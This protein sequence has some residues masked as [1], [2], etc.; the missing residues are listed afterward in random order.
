MQRRIYRLLP[1]LLLFSASL[2]AAGAS[3]NHTERDANSALPFAPAEVLIYEGEYSRGLLRGLNIAEI[4]FS[5]DRLQDAQS[6][7]AGNQPTAGKLRFKAEAV[8]KGFLLQKVL[9]AFHQQ[10]ESTVDPQTFAVLQTNKLDEQGNRVR[11]SQA[12]FNNEKVVWTERDPRNP[13]R[14][15][16]TVTTALNGSALDIASAVYFLR[17]QTLSTGRSFELTIS[18][19][20]RVYRVPVKV[21]ETKKMKT[22]LGH[23][24]VVR[25]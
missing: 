2:F 7:P 18:D 5:F 6:A 11:A 13:N 22:V 16:R 12:V 24:R 21:L 20:G 23:V 17:T 1:L 4:R 15:P 9:G 8:S 3:A 25:V 10:V 19:S 14:E